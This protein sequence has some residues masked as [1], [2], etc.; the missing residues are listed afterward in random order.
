M[1]KSHIIVNSPTELTQNWAQN[2]INQQALDVQVKQVN[3]LNV[4]VGTTTRVR[5]QVNHNGSETLAQHWFVKLP[6]LARRAKLITTLPCLLHTEVRF[7]NEIAPFVPIRL[8]QCLFAQSKIG[9]G[10]T[11]VLADVKEFSA[12]ASSPSDAL[13]LAQASE[14]VQQL[15]YFHAHFW[16]QPQLS[17]NYPWLASSVR[18]LENGLGMALAVP[19]MKRGLKLAGTLIS[20]EL[21]T[22]AIRYAQQRRRIM[23]F[24]D[25]APQTLIHRDCHAGNLFWLNNNVGLLDWQ[26]VR[27]GE[28]IADVAYFMATAL[29]P[30]VRRQHQK[31]LLNLYSQTL[32][33]HGVTELN[34]EQLMQRYRAH[35]GYAFEAMLITLAVGG[36]MKLEDNLELIRRTTATVQ[37]LDTFSVLF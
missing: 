8:P 19:L 20:K 17:L 21:H 23:A 5:L 12:T 3:I 26:L 25:D 2:I 24:L 1:K 31:Q 6:S 4:D 27:L 28:G 29:Q 34:H 32:Q 37:D 10:S 16:Q 36:M 22:L 7:Y 11:L 14:V 15:A 13:N 18:R 9:R 35:C 33:K 30:E